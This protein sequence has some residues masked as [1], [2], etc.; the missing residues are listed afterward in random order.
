[1]HYYFALLNT[2]MLH[3]HINRLQLKLKPLAS[4]SAEQREAMEANLERSKKEYNGDPY[5]FQGPFLLS[6]DS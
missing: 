3:K 2:V 6:R 1:V 4:P 5:G